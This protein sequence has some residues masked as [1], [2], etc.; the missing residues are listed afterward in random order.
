[1]LL[2][3][4]C[5]KSPVSQLATSRNS[6]WLMFFRGAFDPAFPNSHMNSHR[7]ALQLLVK[8]SLDAGSTSCG[9]FAAVTQGSGHTVGSV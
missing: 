9:K 2:P 5:L 3:A 7:I 4:N 8:H 6:T 1:M